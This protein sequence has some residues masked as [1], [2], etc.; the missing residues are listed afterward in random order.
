MTSAQAFRLAYR[1]PLTE[2]HLSPPVAE[3]GGGF[4]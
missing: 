1:R 2:E 3:F 4:F